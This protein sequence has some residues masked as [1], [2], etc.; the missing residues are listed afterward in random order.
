MLWMAILGMLAGSVPAASGD[1]PAA[2][3]AAGQGI[4]VLPVSVEPGE[5][6]PRLVLGDEIDRL[7]KDLKLPRRFEGYKPR[8]RVE[9]RTF[10]FQHVS[11]PQQSRWRVV[12]D[13][14]KAVALVLS[15]DVHLAAFDPQQARPRLD[16]PTGRYHMDHFIGPRIETHQLMESLPSDAN[17]PP[18]ELK[19]RQP[20]ERWIASGQSLTFLRTQSTPSREVTNRITFTVDPVYGYRIDC[21]YQA[22]FNEPPA[23]VRMSG[24]SYCPGIYIPWPEAELYDYTIYTRAGDGPGK[25]HGWASNLYCI[26]RCQRLPFEDPGFI[27]YLSKDPNGWSPCYSRSD[28]V[29]PATIGQC[30][31][32][33]GPGFSY[34][35][36]ALKAG[37]DGKYAFRA[38]RRLFALPPEA[39]KHI[40]DHTT[41]HQAGVKGVFLRIGTEEGFEEQPIDLTKPTRGLIW[42][43]GGPPVV[44]G[45]AHSGRKSLKIAGRE[46]PNLPQVVLQPRTRYRLEGWFKVVPWTAEELAKVKADDEKKRQALAKAGKPLPPV[47]DWDKAAPRAYIRGDLFEW[48]PHTGPMLVKQTTNDAT[49]KTG[50]WQYVSLEFQTPD[51]DPFINISLNAENCTAYL[52][53]FRLAPAGQAP[54]PK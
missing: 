44:D 33:H 30:N 47:V 40:L 49:G 10:T 5:A 17:M 52:D 48:S 46:W 43:A 34:A 8:F 7:E 19:R 14:D 26:D 37:A 13:G 39:R 1:A 16:L 23:K 51:W 22:A 41:L 45:I 36:P 15:G 3:G 32:G 18:A 2:T 11:G 6:P 28:S 27:A 35:L 21:T 25:Y 31:A 54:G 42:T 4:D 12:L 24:H 53:D 50:E 38:S 29:G 20:R 9:W